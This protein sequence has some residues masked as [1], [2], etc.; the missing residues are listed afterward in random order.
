MAKK[1]AKAKAKAKPKAAPKAAPKKAKAKAKK[2][3]ARKTARAAAPKRAANPAVVHW[4]VQAKDPARQQSFFGNLFGWKIDTNNPMNYGMFAGAGKDSIGGGIGPA[5]DE[6]SRVTVY[7]QVADID[8]T[9]AKAQSLGAE[10]LMPRTP[11][12]PVIMALF[13]DLERNVIGLVEG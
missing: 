6:T 12:G 5:M 9:L 4:E 3:A 10:T 8:A 7:V 13:R 11:Y 1:K 2:P